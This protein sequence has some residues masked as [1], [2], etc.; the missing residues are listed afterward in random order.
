MKITCLSCI[1]WT[2]TQCL[3]NEVGF[4]DNDESCP[5]FDYE[6]GSDEEEIDDE[7]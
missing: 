1:N 5:N 3:L 6:P 7:L 4:P 2:R